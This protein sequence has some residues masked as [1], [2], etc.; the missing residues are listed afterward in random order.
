MQ[1]MSFK[2]SRIIASVLTIVAAL[3]GELTFP[4]LG[5]SSFTPSRPIFTTDSGS[6]VVQLN[7]TARLTLSAEGGAVVAAYSTMTPDI[8]S[9]SADGVVTGIH[10]GTCSILASI[11]GSDNYLVTTPTVIILTVEDPAA[12][13]VAKSSSNKTERSLVV[14][15]RSGKFNI[16]LVLG[17]NH[18]FKEVQLQIGIRNSLGRISYKGISNLI[19]DNQGKASITR[20]ATYAKN[21]YIRALMDK[22]VILTKKII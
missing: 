17:P 8:C 11:T 9:V 22:K 3:V 2:I 13:Q 5:A 18:K 16:S 6:N 19:L 10:G 21:I 15:R 1:R 7:K 12:A 4:A 14:A 20:N